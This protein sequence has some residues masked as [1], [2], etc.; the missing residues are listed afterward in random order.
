MGVGTVLGKIQSGF[1][2]N[3]V[4]TDG[5]YFDP[6]TRVTSIWLAGE[7]KFIA[8][9]HKVKLAGKWDLIIKDKSYE[10]ELDVPSLLK[11]DKNRNQ[12]ALANNQ[13]EGKINSGDVSL[14]LNELIIDGS[15]I[16]YKLE[17]TLLGN[18]AVSIHI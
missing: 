4:V 14:N 17:G 3:L 16:E 11:K 5:N 10:L 1:I 18:D 15:Q 8:D 2:A 9:K 7:E 6:R 13:L 12:I